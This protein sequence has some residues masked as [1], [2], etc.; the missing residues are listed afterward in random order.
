MARGDCPAQKGHLKM[1][2]VHHERHWKLLPG[3]TLDW[4]R[5]YSI[6]GSVKPSRHITFRF[7]LPQTKG[8]GFTPLSISLGL[9][10]GGLPT[11]TPISKR[12]PEREQSPAS[13]TA[14]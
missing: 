7:F 4:I 2:R 3:V 9:S 6:D 14:S 10:Q 5:F 12:S 1:S 11:T 13:R 8:I